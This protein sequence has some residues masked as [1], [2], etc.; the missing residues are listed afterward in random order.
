VEKVCVPIGYAA[1]FSSALSHCGGAKGRDDYVYRLFA[2]IVSNDVDYLIGTI[3]RNCD[4][5]NGKRV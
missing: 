1:I 2:Y 4:D 5:D 3:E